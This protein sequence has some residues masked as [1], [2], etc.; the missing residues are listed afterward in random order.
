MYRFTLIKAELGD[1]NIS[2]DLKFSFCGFAH[3]VKRR[4][5]N[6]GFPRCRN[7]CVTYAQAV[8]SSHN[9][10]HTN[11]SPRTVVN[12]RKELLRSLFLSREFA[13]ASLRERRDVAYIYPS[14]DPYGSALT[15]K[16]LPIYI[17]TYMVYPSMDALR[18]RYISYL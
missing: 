18:S 12:A 3:Y 13:L 7:T 4:V 14:D 8:A 10:A 11:S 1:E 17:H 15:P 2:A 9:T 6:C 16:P 5:K